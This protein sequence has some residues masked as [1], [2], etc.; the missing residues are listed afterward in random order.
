M[1]RTVGLLEE[2]HF[3]DILLFNFKANGKWGGREKS[4]FFSGCRPIHRTMHKITTFPDTIC[5]M[6]W[7][8]VIV[9]Y[10]FR[11]HSVWG[12]KMCLRK[13]DRLKGKT[14]INTKRGVCPVGN[15]VR[16]DVPMCT[17][18]R[19]VCIRVRAG[20]NVCLSCRLNTQCPPGF[21]KL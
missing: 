8:L 5:A 9:E 18:M 1:I 17:F 12:I 6:D 4:V 7:G 11:E 3:M 19:F 20:V 16:S 21:I 2:N 14:K 15:G 10:R 13:F